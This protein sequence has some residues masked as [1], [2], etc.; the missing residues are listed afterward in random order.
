MV[1]LIKLIEEYGNLE[2]ELGK[3]MGRNE[4]L[5]SSCTDKELELRNKRTEK[6]IKLQQ[7]VL[8]LNRELSQLEE[9]AKYHS[10][11]I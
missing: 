1:A 11:L 2:N 10:R 6:Y 7:E 9:F 3:E 8:R 5:N 4:T